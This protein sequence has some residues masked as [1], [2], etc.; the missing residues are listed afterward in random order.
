MDITGVGSIEFTTTTTASNKVVLPREAYYV[1]GIMANLISNTELD[2]HGWYQHSFSKEI[3]Q[4]LLNDV[5]VMRS[6][7]KG[8]L[9]IMN[10]SVNYPEDQLHTH[11]SLLVSEDLP[12]H[13]LCHLSHA[14][15]EN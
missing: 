10:L 15:M 5:E 7:V 3:K 13:R 4:F 6:C 9:W 8:G 2:K 12:H 1:P 11:V 14:N